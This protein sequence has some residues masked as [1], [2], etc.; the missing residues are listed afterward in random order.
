M[1]EIEGIKDTNRSLPISCVGGI[2]ISQAQKDYVDK[3]TDDFRIGDLIEAKVTKVLGIDNADLTTAEE[4]LGV[5]K[6]MCTKCRYFMN[7]IGKNQVKCPNCGNKETR[8]LSSK[9]E[10]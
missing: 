9:Y 2:N 5:L 3:L 7:K 1:V 10:G 8:K 6:A 4:E